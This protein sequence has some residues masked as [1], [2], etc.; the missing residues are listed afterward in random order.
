MDE[1]EIQL[2]EEW[3]SGQEMGHHRFVANGMNAVASKGPCPTNLDPL[4]PVILIKL[5]KQRLPYLSILVRVGW[6][7]SRDTRGRLQLVLGDMQRRAVKILHCIDH[8]VNGGGFMGLELS[9]ILLKDIGVAAAKRPEKNHDHQDRGDGHLGTREV[10][11][12]AIKLGALFPNQLVLPL[13]IIEE[14]LEAAEGIGHRLWLTVLVE[15]SQHLEPMAI[16]E[17]PLALKEKM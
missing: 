9:S 15:C 8:R 10:I 2:L 1:P 4:L 5:F 17:G 7:S 6:G 13:D 3:A 14:R 16:V 11:D 12:K